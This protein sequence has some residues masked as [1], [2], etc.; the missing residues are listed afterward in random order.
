MPVAPNRTPTASNPRRF[1]RGFSLLEVI[2]A[3]AILAVVGAFALPRFIVV[4]SQREEKAIVEVED[5][6]RM[7]AFR[8]SAGLQQVSLHYIRDSSSLTLWIMD[9]NPLDPEGPRIWQQD[10]LS[11]AIDF[12]E[13]FVIERAMADGTPMAD[14]EWTIATNPDGSRPRIELVLR[15]E[16]RTAQLV[17]ENFTNAPVRADDPDARV[18]QPIDLDAE[19]GAYDPW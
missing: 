11:A 16:D 9:L 7:F 12:P 2:V 15:G 6:L 1:R 18:L 4:G 19:G 10:R 3:C 17:L 13:G 5:L 14:D 8:N